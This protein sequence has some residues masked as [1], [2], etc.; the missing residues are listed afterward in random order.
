MVEHKIHFVDPEAKDFTLCSRGVKEVGAT[1]K[2][3][4][5]TCKKCLMELGRRG[6]IKAEAKTDEEPELL[7]T[8]ADAVTNALVDA[9][10]DV[11]FL[12]KAWLEGDLALVKSLSGRLEDALRTV[13]KEVQKQLWNNLR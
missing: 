11:K 6:M 1:D 5:V 12:T 13:K 2:A 3:K 4:K 10:S 7:V 9:E 8:P